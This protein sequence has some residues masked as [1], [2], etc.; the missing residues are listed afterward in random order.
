MINSKLA[1]VVLW[2]VGALLSFS[3]MAV[4]IRQLSRGGLSIFEILAIRSGVALVV[5]VALLAVR[6]ELRVHARPRRMGL[7]LFRNSV[8]Y[9]SQFMWA[10]SLTMLPLAMV[11]ALEFTMPAWTALL[12]VWFL[13]ERMTPSRLGVVV[14]GLIGVL[15]ILRP[16]I[17]GFNPAALL[18]L[19][20]AFGYAITM[21]TTKKLTMTESTFG[22]VFWMAVMQFPL[23]L[24]GSDPAVFFHFEARH[25]LPAIGVGLAGLSSHY[26]L[27][28]AF[29]SGDAT[30]VVPLDF[31]R[32]PLIAVVGWAF[33]GESLDI[34]VLLGALD[35]YFGGV[36]EPAVRSRKCTLTQGSPRRNFQTRVPRMKSSF[37]KL[38]AAL[39]ACS[40][41]AAAQAQSQSSN[42]AC[43][44]LE[45]QL[46]DARSRKCRSGTRRPDSAV[47]RP[48]Q[49][50]AIRGGQAGRAIAPDGLRKL[51]LLLDFQQSSRA[52]RSAQPADRPAA[53]RPRA[54]AES[55]LNDSMAAQPSAR[56]S[57]RHC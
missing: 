43:Q 35:H 48:G 36:L 11:F 47:G 45:T 15:V 22:I 20:A 53:Q 42:P 41:L 39:I 9:G 10:L 23:S 54:H 7:N 51:R 2:M 29:R 50:P 44:R 13:H 8:H 21:I 55:I 49:P 30:L 52:M 12:A 1:R 4:S 40:S 31:M 18:V 6:P 25:I 56:P 19:L 28:N 24:I 38:T 26:C 5:L 33:Y 46:G 27:S 37:Y 16:G 57:A 32:I 34:F 14:L 3:V 17:A